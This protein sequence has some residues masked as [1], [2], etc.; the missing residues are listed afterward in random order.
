MRTLHLLTFSCCCAL[1]LLLQCV[2]PVYANTNENKTANVPAP[3]KASLAAPMM[4]WGDFRGQLMVRLFAGY[5]QSW[6]GE[7]EAAQQFG[8]FDMREF[9]L[10]LRANWKEMVGAV[11][12][13]EVIRSADPQSLFGIDGDSYIFRVQQA[14]AYGRIGIWKLSFELRAGLIRE[15]W[16]ELVQQ[17]YSI[18]EMG[19]LQSQSAEFFAPAELGASIGIKGWDGLVELRYALTNGEGLNQTEQNNGK[20]SMLSL[21]FR[22]LRMALFGRPSVLALHVAYRDGSLGAGLARNHRIAGALT[23]AMPGYNLG[24]EYVVG[25][26]WRG[27]GEITADSLSI[28]LQA[29][30]YKQWIGVLGRFDRLNTNFEVDDAVRTRISAGVYSDLLRMSLWK[31]KQRF[32]L[33][34]LYQYDSRGAN[35]GPFPGIPA[36][37]TNHQ[38]MFVLAVNARVGQIRR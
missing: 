37:L 12:R 31:T 13:I 6:L 11:F 5:F 21:S 2:R 28:W 26:G 16:I 14:W 10:G 25:L 18:R 36:A 33:F 1:V 29:D 4:D 27:A 8:E 38:L 34:V 23:F 22:P 35:S 30:L 24:A 20:N 9:Q 19:P 7:G 17:G 15:P 3:S 32:R